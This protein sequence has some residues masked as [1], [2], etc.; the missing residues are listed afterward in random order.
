MESDY[1]VEKPLQWKSNRMS[2]V[3]ALSHPLSRPQLPPIPNEGLEEGCSCSKPVLIVF[4]HNFISS[5][6]R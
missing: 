6:Y 1:V 5:Y 2:L 3:L 4:I